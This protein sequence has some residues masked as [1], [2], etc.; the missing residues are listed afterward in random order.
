VDR[1]DRALAVSRAGRRVLVVAGSDS[2]GGAGL[3]RDLATL[4]ALGC[5]G[6]VAVTAV[7]AQTHERVER[8]LA[9]PPDLIAAQ[10]RAAFASGAVAAVKIGMLPGA[11]AVE[12]VAGELRDRAGIPVVL[13]PVI[14]STSGATF[15][16]GAA[17][18]ALAGALMPRADLITPNLAELAALGGGDVG[19]EPCAIATARRLLRRGARA[20]LVKGGHAAGASATDILVNR[21]GTVER[22]AA[23]RIAASRRGTGCALSSAIACHMALGVRLGEACRRAK[24]MVWSELAG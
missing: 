3:A 13:D 12:A 4:A 15:L 18:E 2:S 21:D 20:I 6:A 5:T 23:E 19:D 24:A 8:I 17:I 7:T 10:M 16:D 14:A 1:G 9:M 11:A 22:F